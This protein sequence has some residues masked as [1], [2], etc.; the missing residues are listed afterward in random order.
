[1]QGEQDQAVAKARAVYSAALGNLALARGLAAAYQERTRM[2]RS[3]L[4][5]LGE[6]AD[7]LDHPVYLHE[8]PVEPSKALRESG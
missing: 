8:V 6:S 7:S 4:L 3:A 5:A 1:M 2:A